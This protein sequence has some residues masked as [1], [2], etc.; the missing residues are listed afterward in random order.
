[1][2]KKLLFCIAFFALLIL[3]IGP[4][5]AAKPENNGKP[6]DE[7]FD[8]N[9]IS[10]G[11]QKLSWHLSASLTAAANEELEGADKASKLI[12]NQPRGETKL[13]LNGI[14]KGLTPHTT[15]TVSLFSNGQQLVTSNWSISGEWSFSCLGSTHQIIITQTGDTFTG[16]GTVTRTSPPSIY[17]EVI[18]GTINRATG[19][20]TMHGTFYNDAAHQSPNGYMYTASLVISST[21]SMA[22]QLT[23]AG[24]VGEPIVSTNGKAVNQAAVT[25]TESVALSLDVPAITFT[26]S[27]SG[28]GNWHLNLKRDDFVSLGEFDL[29]L[30]VNSADTAVLVSES[31]AVLAS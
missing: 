25:E 31:F 13:T 30:V 21:G 17:Y 26:T 5:L 4:V 18:T 14:M 10:H 3:T 8:A 9:D 23:N 19:Q 24:Q 6:K 29:T 1:M 2:K 7:D 20:I 15:Y 11:A 22:G 27:G 28:N 12:V 16:V